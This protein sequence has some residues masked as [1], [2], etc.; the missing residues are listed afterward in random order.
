MKHYTAPRLVA[1]GSVIEHTQGSLF[2]YVDGGDQIAYPAGSVG[3]S[4]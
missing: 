4:L 3:F 2:G 1:V